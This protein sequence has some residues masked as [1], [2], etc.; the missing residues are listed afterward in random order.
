MK[1]LN[2]SSASKMPK[3]LGGAIGVKYKTFYI[4]RHAATPD[5]NKPNPLY[6]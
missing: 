4:N 1:N 5:K 2:A 3:R 6:K